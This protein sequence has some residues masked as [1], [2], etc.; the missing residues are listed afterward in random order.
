MSELN[1]IDMPLSNEDFSVVIPCYNRAWCIEKAIL[2]AVEF[3]DNRNGAE[4][5]V[6]D[7]G[8]KDETI[9]IVEALFAKLRNINC[10]IRLN[11]I[12][13]DKNL[14]VCATKNTG[15]RLASG[16]WIIFLDS[17]DE[18]ISGT[19]EE[20]Q[21]SLSSNADLPLHFFRCTSSNGLSVESSCLTVDRRK[22]SDY[23]R[24]GTDGEALP[25]VKKDVFCQFPYDEDISGYES[26][27]Y[28]RIAKVHRYVCIHELVA[29]RYNVS[30][31]DRLSSAK[32]FKK[33]SR[34]LAKGHLRII[35]EH[36]SEMNCFTVAKYVLKF[37]RMRFVSIFLFLS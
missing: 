21:K 29:R 27:A 7:D 15:A 31:L 14:G 10:A 9:K 17:D 36:F 4:I 8:S 33:R 2:S 32:N 30:H 28:M 23:L 16:K 3:L 19:F 24:F 35:S 25:V 37:L 5:V 18:L 11:L 26:L 20:M 1:K 12:R 22:F 13:Q 34:G 6:V